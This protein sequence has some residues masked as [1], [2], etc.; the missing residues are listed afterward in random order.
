[1]LRSWYLRVSQS[2]N[3]VALLHHVQSEGT[4]FLYAL[5]HSLSLLST[6]GIT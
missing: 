1:M 5:T 4:Y 6:N 3:L 2:R